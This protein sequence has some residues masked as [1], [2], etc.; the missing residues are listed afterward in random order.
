M[1]SK[2]NTL[3]FCLG[4]MAS[5]LG[6]VLLIPVVVIALPVWA[7]ATLTKTARRIFEP[8]STPWQEIIEYHP[9]IGWRPKA[10]LTAHC[11]FAAGTFHLR[12]ADDGWPGATTFAQS[13]M[14]VI[15]DSY[16]LGFGVD[17]RRAFYSVC[18]DVQIKAI[19]A[20]GYSMV[21]EV[22]WMKRYARQLHGKLVVWFLCYSNDLY[23]NLLPNLYHYRTPFAR[24]DMNGT[25]QIVNHHVTTEPWPFNYEHNFRM[26]EKFHGVFG[27]NP[28][29]ERVYAACEYLIREGRDACR[30][31][32]ASLV[33]LS[34]PWPIQLDDV[35]WR[36]R[37]ARHGSIDD[38]DRYAPDR[39]IGSICA[40]LN[41]SLIQG[42]E[43]LDVRHHIPAEG[44]WNERGH[45]QIARLLE[46][47][48]EQ[49]KESSRAGLQSHEWR[50][51]KL[52]LAAEN[53]WR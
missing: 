3:R 25:W 45:R 49:W 50:T 9:E 17:S 18:K 4:L 26:E 39:K 36:R 16:A 37:C 20:P 1:D 34:V 28:L 14:V 33:L 32:G 11:E 23:D 52:D 19:G 15:G 10:N 47:V 35:E 12:T 2:T 44:H 7:V 51:A 40:D 22:L 38:F 21:H 42:R 31:A 30:D 24:R 6:L 13:D 48:H 5:V 46:Q 43:W 27:E 41:V 29:A 8:K 53:W